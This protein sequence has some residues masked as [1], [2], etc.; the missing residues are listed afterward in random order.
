MTAFQR[1]LTA[2]L[3]VTLAVVIAYQWLDRPIA[4]F[5]HHQLPHHGRNLFEPLTHIPD[6]LIPA[7]VIAFVVL[8]LW[9][10]AGRP[11]TR[12]PATVVGCSLSVTMVQA[13]KNLLKFAFGRTWPE[14]WIDNNPS[15][16][17]D[18]AYGFHWFHGGG[19]YESFPS[20]HMAVTCAVL[21]VL[22]ICYP[23]LK[24]LYLLAGLAVAVG[25]VGANFHFLSDVIAG[26][27]VGISVG[28]MA[29]ALF[30]RLA[31]DGPR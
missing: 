10:L 6:P 17:R 7:A 19:G 22:W 24:P 20:G 13:F 18:D 12:L 21:S 11:L 5:V 1:W 8:G 26:S 3:L 29:V 23:R 25:L 27:F 15:F 9:A 28:W 14:T 4:L 2:L 16:I 30:D 31:P